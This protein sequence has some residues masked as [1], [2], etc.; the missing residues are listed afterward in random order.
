[1]I[2][3]FG[4]VVKSGE[5]TLIAML[6]FIAKVAKIEGHH[7]ERCR[8][9]VGRLEHLLS[10]LLCVKGEEGMDLRSGQLI[11]APFLPSAAEVKA[12]SQR[13]GYWKLEAVLQDGSY[14]YIT[15]NL[16]ADQL[17]QMQIVQKSDLQPVEDAED[18]FLYMEA[19]R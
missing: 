7:F 4:G 18:F 3:G 14:Q 5:G 19:N 2:V 16:T 13:H 9:R 17:A 1:M 12:F 8:S 10:A 6:S 15:Q 11:S